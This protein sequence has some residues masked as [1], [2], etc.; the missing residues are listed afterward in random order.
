[1]KAGERWRKLLAAG[2]ED[3]EA[4]AC[5]ARERF[6]NQTIPARPPTIT[7]SGNARRFTLEELLDVLGLAREG[8][9]AK[10]DE[11]VLLDEVLALQAHFEFLRLGVED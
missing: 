4:L 9:A 1:M 5:A 7:I 11:S 6:V 8:Q 3:C 10:L 2:F